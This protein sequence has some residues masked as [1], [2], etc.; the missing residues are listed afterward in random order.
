MN[1]TTGKPLKEWCV[2]GR[3]FTTSSGAK[4]HQ[5]KCPQEQARSAAYLQ[6]IEAGAPSPVPDAARI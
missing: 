2:C 6:W 4:H 1:T 3:G 5:E